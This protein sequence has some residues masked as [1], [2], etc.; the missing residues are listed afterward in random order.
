MIAWVFNLLRCMANIYWH[1]HTFSYSFQSWKYHSLGLEVPLIHDIP[2]RNKWAYNSKTMIA[3]VFNL[4]RCMANI[5]WH[6]F[7]FQY[8]FQ[9]WK[10]IS[11]GLEVLLIHDIPK[12]NNCA[13]NTSTMIAWVFSLLRFMSNI[14]WHPHTFS[15]SFQSW[16]YHSLGLEVLLIHDIPKGTNG[17][18]TLKPW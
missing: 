18:I 17:L 1:S 5:Y 9:S 6:S 8:S 3:W 12:R 7:T 13:Y 4:L 10:Y 16:K 15:Y 11:L 14:Y 2:K